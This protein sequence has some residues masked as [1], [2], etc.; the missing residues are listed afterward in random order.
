MAGEKSA[1]TPVGSKGL[2]EVGSPNRIQRRTPGAANLARPRHAHQ[3]IPSARQC[4]AHPLP[5]ACTRAPAEGTVALL[6]LA[7]YFQ[8]RI[9]TYVVR[10]LEHQP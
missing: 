7:L 4:P 10:Q 6:L 1:N 9:P 3:P 8:R 5:S 2:T